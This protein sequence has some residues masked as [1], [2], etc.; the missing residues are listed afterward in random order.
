MPLPVLAIGAVALAVIVI[1]IVTSVRGEEAVVQDRLGRYAET[2][3]DTDKDA[4]SKKDK[5]EVSPL[6][7]GLN[8]ALE[9]RSF[10]DNLATQLARADIK[11]TVAEFFALQIIAVM[12]AFAAAFVLFGGI[13]PFIAAIAGFFGPRI[14]VNFRR[15]ARLNTFNDQ[16]GDAIMQMSNGLRAGY[17]V[18]QAMESVATELPTPI[19]DEFRRVVQEMQLGVGMEQALS[20]MLRRIDSEDLDLMITAI[21]VQ[22]E[23]GG[24]LADILDVISFTIRE[25][26]RIKGEVRTLTSQG[27]M[28]GYVI[29]FLPFGLALLLM[30]LNRD[31]IMQVFQST[32]GWIMVILTVV[33][34][35]AG[36]FA[37]NKITDI[38][39]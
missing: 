10:A 7:A 6:T 29:G 24:N 9:G 31:Y 32:C 13:L 17:S 3:R 23:V 11:V 27:R 22:R 18:L 14:Y 38:E 28:S 20:N 36:M 26:V 1:G 2:E 19:C 37:M 8:K 30:V 15:N 34:V 25:R 16:L 12:G 4:D 33:L 39:V 5:D 21:N 35:G